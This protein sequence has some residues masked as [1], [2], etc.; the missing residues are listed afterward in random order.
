MDGG[1]DFWDAVDP[2]TQDSSHQE[3]ATFHEPA[4]IPQTHE[5]TTTIER[6]AWDASRFDLVGSLLHSMTIAEKLCSYGDCRLNASHLCESCTSRSSFCNEHAQHHFSL[7]HCC[8]IDVRGDHINEI[9]DSSS[10]T[11]LVTR[12]AWFYSRKMS[13]K[14][15]LDRHFFPGSPQQPVLGFHIKLLKLAAEMYK[16]GDMTHE[17]IWKFQYCLLDGCLQCRESVLSFNIV[18]WMVVYNAGNLCGI[19]N[20]FV[21]VSA[22]CPS[23][24][25]EPNKWSLKV[26]IQDHVPF[27]TLFKAV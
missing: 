18:Y 25:K 6:K 12:D 3:N 9:G 14:E 26:Y 11:I 20:G 16:S 17:K 22:T 23:L 5:E 27:K 13:V 8:L 1:F 24:S 10:S 2:S 19:S 4:P 7:L 21:S 15:L